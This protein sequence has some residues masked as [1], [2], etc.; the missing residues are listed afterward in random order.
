MRQK[1]L[2]RAAAVIAAAFLILLALSAALAP[3][4]AENTA[5]EREAIFQTLLPGGGPYVE[6]PY[7]GE[8]TN[9]STVYRGTTG[10]IVETVTAGYA[11]DITM[12]V[13]VDFQGTVVGAVVRDMEETFGL[14]RNALTD[15]DFLVQ[16]VG[17]S[18]EAEVGGGVDAITGA[19]VTSRA[20]ARGVS[21]ACAYVTGADVS[22][23]ATEWGG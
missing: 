19:T 3:L 8:D 11:G 23:S 10:Y 21:S 18:G 17:T 22:T 16:F 13:A 2:V 6:E 9:I 15:I 7:S 12:L 20:V 4:E 5:A 14:G 1:S